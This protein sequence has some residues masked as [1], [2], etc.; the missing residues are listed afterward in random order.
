VSSTIIRRASPTCVAASPT[1]GASYIVCTMLATKWFSVPSIFLT[2]FAAVL[3]TGSGNLRM[4]SSAIAS[5]CSIYQ[6]VALLGT[7][8]FAAVAE[9]NLGD[10]A[11]LDL[12]GA[13]GDP[14]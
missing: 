14:I 8:R 11:D 6:S 10:A 5:G 9:E 4:R 12:L 13:L 3:S 7:A 2:G 1:P